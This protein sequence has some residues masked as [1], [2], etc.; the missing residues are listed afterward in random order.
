MVVEARPS[1]RHEADVDK[2]KEA[3]AEPEH[4]A[5]AADSCVQSSWLP[6]V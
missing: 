3:D 5:A 4:G 6:R 2:V 1:R